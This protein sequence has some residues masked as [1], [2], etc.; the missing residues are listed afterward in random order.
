MIV[1]LDPIPDFYR[2]SAAFTFAVARVRFVLL[3]IASSLSTG[4]A[5]RAIEPHPA[6]ARII[7]PEQSATS[8]GS[9]TLIDVRDQYGLVVTNWH[10]IRDA[11]G[12][13]E[14][15]FPN[16]FRCAARP[17]KLDSNWD[18][19]ALVIWRPPIEP[20]AISRHPPQPGDPLMICGYGQGDYRA[21]A[22]RCTQ[23]YAPRVDYPHELLE[24]DVEARQGD[25][26]GPIFNAQGE[27]AGVL[28]GAGRGTTMGSYGGRVHS[29]LASLAPDIGEPAQQVAAIPPPRMNE[30]A[31]AGGAEAPAQHRSDR[32]ATLLPPEAVADAD[33]PSDQLASHEFSPNLA[34]ERFVSP[35]SASDPFAPMQAVTSSSSVASRYSD[36]TI[37][38]N[39]P[40][41]AS[42]QAIETT[43]EHALRGDAGGTSL[44]SQLTTLLAIIGAIAL[45]LQL[46]KLA[47]R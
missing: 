29:F 42:L 15:V 39:D 14:V 27:L 30:M 10:V 3:L 7:V 9:G 4:A 1:R 38:P 12:P 43:P 17:L 46:S 22:G 41:L 19:A 26:G 13:P 36:T 2:Y 11:V 37:A 25:S 21:A 6:V 24:L 23:Y 35:Q 8:Y 34:Q 33:E 47:A 40:P 45:V 28:F 32:P 16:G 5:A 20:V 44:V 31:S 18:L